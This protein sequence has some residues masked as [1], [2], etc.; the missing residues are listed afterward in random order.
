MEW[1]LIVF[2]A[3]A[4]HV[5]PDFVDIP[6]RSEAVCKSLKKRLWSDLEE[7]TGLIFN[8]TCESRPRAVEE[9]PE[10]VE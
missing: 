10:S 3:M 9:E 1:F 8:L 2:T 6:Q 7:T 5:D 4:P